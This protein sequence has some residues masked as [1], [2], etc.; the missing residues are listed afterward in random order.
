MW[1]DGDKGLR[2]TTLKVEEIFL[3]WLGLGLEL[4]SNSHSRSVLTYFQRAKF[5]LR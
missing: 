4:Q 5:V 3:Y 1:K 2:S